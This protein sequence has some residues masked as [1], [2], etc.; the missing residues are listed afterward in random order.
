LRSDLITDSLNQRDALR[1]LWLAREIPLPLSTG[2]K[3]YTARL[4]QA[5]A[6]A[7]ASVTFMGLATSVASTLRAAAVFENRIEWSIVPGQPNP[8]VLALASPLP[9][10]AARF[11]TRNY[12]QHLRGMLRARDF[13]VVILDQYSMVW[14]I[15]CIQSDENRRASTLLA[16]IAHN[17]E[18]EL[19]ADTARNFRGN[20][21]R[22]AALRA[23]AS[24]TAKAERKLVGAADIIVTL[25]SEDAGSLAPLSPSTPKLVLRP[26]YTGPRALDRQIAQTTPR[27]VVVVGS[28]RWTPKEMNLSAFLESADAI[29]QKAGIGVDVVGEVPE[30]LRKKWEARVK[31]TRFHGFVEDLVEFFASRRLGLVI[32]Q[33]GG[34]FKLK[35]LDYIFNRLPIAA[36]RGSIAGLPLTPGVHYLSFESMQEL[37]QG[38]AA[39]IDDIARLNSLQQTAYEICQTGFDWGDRGRSLYDALRQAVSR[40]RNPDAKD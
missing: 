40:Q 16:Y 38:A 34:G 2:D 1:C 35:T 22:K 8:T 4:A 18:T 29:L 28:Y 24:K 17:F 26:G 27:R 20:P 3:T 6:V 33:T 14:A 30:S 11:G 25:T 19:A 37:A 31:A 9:L 32:E 10:V 36:L 5:L 7:G 21:F 23:N 12:L 39:V 15:D 13:D